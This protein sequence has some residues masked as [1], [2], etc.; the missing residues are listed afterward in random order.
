MSF[1]N[2]KKQSSSPS[3]PGTDW[4]RFFV[5]SSTG[6]LAHR[7]ENGDEID[8]LSTVGFAAITGEPT[9]FPNRTDSTLTFTDGTRT[10]QIA[11]AVSSFTFYVLGQAYTKS[12]AQSV[13]IPDLE[14]GHWVYFDSNGTLQSTPTPTSA[15]FLSNALVAY[16]YWDA[17]ANTGIIVADERHGVVMDGMTHQYLH[18]TFGARYASGLALDDITADGAGDSDS[19]ATISVD[20]GTLY[21]EDILHTITD[22]SP[23]DIGGGDN[24]AQIPIYY[25][26]GSG[27]DWRKIAATN[28]PVTTTG[29]GRA[30]WNQ[31]TG[32]T[33]GLTEVTDGEFVLMHIF[34]TNDT[35]NPIIAVV[36]QVEYDDI[37]SARTG[38]ESEINA[39]VLDDLP[40]AEMVPLGTLI[41][42]T[43]D[44]YT[45]T[46]QSR[47]RSTES[48]GDYVDWRTAVAQ[49]G[50]SVTQHNELLGLQGGAVGAYYHLSTLTAGGDLG[51]TYPN[52]KVA[53]ITE[54][55]GP[56]KL[57]IGAVADG[58]VLTRS[59][60]T[61]IGGSAVFG[62]NYQRQD[63]ASYSSTTG[64]DIV[65][66]TLVTGDLTGTYRVGFGCH[67]R[68][69]NKPCEANIY[70]STTTTVLKNFV[71]K[72]STNANDN[73]STVYSA[74]EVTLTGSSNTL[75][76]RY[77]NISGASD[78]V[79]IADA[80]IEFWRVS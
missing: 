15:L 58:E 3:N 46:V 33:W 50:G 16:I 9:G 40:S 17:T 78:T 53:A 73:G 5:R 34:A 72:P 61:V 20:D 52:P 35:I 62:Q 29:T 24:I 11:P 44:T 36:G 67:L 7:D 27:G 43:D 51:N 75:Q 22:G 77:G 71:E 68:T 57:T 74:V 64:E 47:I 49:S 60:S 13:V 41:Y 66:V 1:L 80:F 63:N 19:H 25:R 79:G 69:N 56:T 6:I 70:N 31:Y 42:Q 30:A 32:G 21:D 12:S 38:A 76:L 14:G 55:G 48:G 54:T 23:Q 8:Y 39:L 37:T 65:R 10:L 2:L 4:I 45:N 18:E 28:F 26:L 59:G